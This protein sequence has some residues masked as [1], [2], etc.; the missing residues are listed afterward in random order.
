MSIWDILGIEETGDK[1]KLKIAYR[2]KLKNTNPEDDQEGFMKLREAYEE[3]IKYADKAGEDSENDKE[4]ERFPFRYN[5]ECLDVLVAI[6]EI[7]KDFN[8]RIKEENWNGIFNRDEFV[9]IDKSE[10]SLDALLNYLT[11]NFLLPHNI[12]KIIVET[13]DIENR[14]KELCEKF[15]KDFIDFVLDNSS[16]IDILNYYLF[17]YDVDNEHVDE[18]IKTYLTLNSCIRRGQ[19]DDTEKLMDK[20]EEFDIYHPYIKLA[21]LRIKIQTSDDER[22]EEN[23]ESAKQLLEDC[24]D[25]FNIISLCGDLAVMLGKYDEAEEYYNNLKAIEPESIAIKVKFADLFYFKK[26]YVAS[27]DAYMELLR[28]N[29]YENTIRAGMLRANMSLI[30]K[31]KSDLE[32]NPDDNDTKIE[33]AWSLYQSYRFEEAVEILDSFEP[34]L[35]KRFEYCNVKG[36]SFLC[37]SDYDNALAYFMCWKEA[38]EDIEE[39]N[40]EEALKKKKRLPYVNFLIASCFL[41]E[42][43]Y[44]KAEQYLEVA[45]ATDHDEII[46][47][48]EAMCELKYVTEKYEECIEACEKLLDLDERNYIAYDYLSKACFKLKYIK[49]AIDACENA[50]RIYP[51]AADPY[52]LEIDI[53]LE[54]GQIDTAKKITDRYKQ[55]EIQSDL[56][57]KKEA[58]ILMK[59]KEYERACKILAGLENVDVKESDIDSKEEI[60][61]LIALCYEN[62]DK[63]SQ[64][65]LYLNKLININP[66]HKSAYGRI[67]LIY[68]DNKKYDMAMEAFDKQ[69]KINPHPYFYYEMA[70]VYRKTGKYAKAIVYYERAA[71]LER[72]NAYIY[73]ELGLL[74]EFL[75]KFEEAVESFDKAIENETDEKRKK[76]LYIFKA[77]NY[78][79]LNRFEQSKK[80][81]EEYAGLYGA[82]YDYI[83]DY[84]EL[85]QRM[86]KVEEAIKL[87][88]DNI[89][90][91]EGNMEAIL[92]RQLCGIYGDEGYVNLANETFRIVVS[93]YPDDK[94]A[95]KIMGD[96]FRNNG[97]YE[98]AID[99]YRNAIRLDFNGRENYYSNL[100]ECMLNVKSYS[101]SEIKEYI[102]KAFERGED[103]TTVR[104]LIMLA[105]INRL[106]KKNKNALAV[107]DKGIMKARCQG[108][109]YRACHEAFYEKGRIYEAMK[110][111]DLARQCYEKALNIMGHCT[112]YEE[113]LKRIDGK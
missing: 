69:I 84:S 89:G 65:L 20:L 46:L 62:L 75:Q 12:W 3:A 37:L 100:V 106:V 5:E 14:K 88:K 45:L 78:Q 98:D 56:I 87:I 1:N 113:S 91:F 90:Q 97:L 29:N 18:F 86:D 11:I 6:D 50:I 24:P 99:C 22:T 82:D 32:S 58:Q 15:P 16:N 42:K 52:A 61:S 35:E 103:A 57:R 63:K 26:D 81:Y 2:E 102:N 47:S 108:C 25:D 27:R 55:Y 96:I 40:S 74:Y 68:R 104:D 39:D 80:I 38:I 59:N 66:G 7:Y 10:D 72:D 54:L 51:Y 83:Y 77:R 79:A 112:L 101:K 4:D 111:Y 21:K 110:K 17:D 53:F 85:L 70:N 34:D 8:E 107:I 105:R 76:D 28:D 64:A 41:K 30:E 48:Y 9:A 94:H 13:F 23:Y 43:E 33:L 92:L 31:Y 49:D 36:R 73:R 19:F 71:E 93:K 60:Y 44:D 95:Y 109:F 67:G